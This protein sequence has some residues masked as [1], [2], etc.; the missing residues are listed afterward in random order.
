MRIFGIEISADFSG[1]QFEEEARLIERYHELADQTDGIA[2]EDMDEEM[3][4]KDEERHNLFCELH[5]NRGIDF[6]WR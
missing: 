5:Y 2:L 6:R 4:A 3:L 1:K